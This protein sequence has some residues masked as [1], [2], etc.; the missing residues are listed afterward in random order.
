MPTQKI[1]NAERKICKLY[2]EYLL[3]KKKKNRKSE[4]DSC[5]VKETM[6]REDLVELFDNSRKNA[7]QLM[8]NKIDKEIYFEATRSNKKI[9]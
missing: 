7:Q 3:L 1:D 5:R 8:K 6:F 9:P 2:G 4:L